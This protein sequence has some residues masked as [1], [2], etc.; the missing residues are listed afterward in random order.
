MS[1]GP[2]SPAESNYEAAK[3]KQR[4][5]QR[6]LWIADGEKRPAKEILRLKLELDAALRDRRR[7]FAAYMEE[8]AA[9]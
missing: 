4:A 6:A 3:A 7:A 8:E 1:K 9:K 5:A 2:M